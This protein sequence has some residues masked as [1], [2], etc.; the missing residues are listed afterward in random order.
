MTCFRQITDYENIG[1][2]FSLKHEHEYTFRYNAKHVHNI[3]LLV[4]ANQ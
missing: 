3:R 4:S 1:L 2:Y